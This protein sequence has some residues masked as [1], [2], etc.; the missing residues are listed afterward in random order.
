MADWV[1]AVFVHPR[2]K[3][4]HVDILDFLSVLGDVMQCDSVGPT[5]EESVAWLERFA[6]LQLMDEVA[7]R[8]VVLH[9]GLV[10]AF[11]DFNEF[12]SLSVYFVLQ[13]FSS[14]GLLDVCVLDGFL[15][16]WQFLIAL[17]VASWGIRAW[18]RQPY[19]S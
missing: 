8:L 16:A 12:P 2:V 4:T 9:L 6:Y 5:T 3:R 1:L 11:P 10:L 17:R 7:H 14:T 13:P 19:N 18:Q 15:V